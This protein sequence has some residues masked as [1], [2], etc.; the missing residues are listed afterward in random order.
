MQSDKIMI[1][2]LMLVCPAVA[3]LCFAGTS[4]RQPEADELLTKYV[5]TLESVRSFIVKSE[6]T[7]E[8]QWQYSRNWREPGFRGRGHKGTTYERLEI[9]TD[10]ERLHERS[11]KWGQI[12]TSFPSVSKDQ[13]TY[14]CRN[15]AN[16]ELY[17]HS[18]HVYPDSSGG[19]VML[20]KPQSYSLGGVE[21]R[22][23]GYVVQT[24]ER[25][26]SVLSR[27]KSISVRPGTAKIGDSDCYVI[28][29]ETDC[30]RVTVWIDPAHGY[31]LARAEVKA[32]EGDLYFGKPLNKEQV[33]SNHIEIRRFEKV[34]SIWIPMEVEAVIEN[35]YGP[36]SYSMSKER[37]KRT[38][39]VL[40]PDHNDL[41]SFDNPL[42]NP[43]NDP[44]LINGT[45]VHIADVPDRYKWQDGKVV[46]ANDKV[47]IDFRKKASEGGNNDANP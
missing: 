3:P 21:R 37:Y 9:R 27:T 6:S 29:A 38:E 36:G 46:D 15:Y 7:V 17:R 23:Q 30:G 2:I 31:H 4:N 25:V 32:T 16:G 28:D 35:H 26:D 22:L 41:D 24:H 13:P 11:Y 47:I 12:S 33:I 10:G 5:K 34:D 43:E 18:M 45:M 40:N 42:E 19:L 44:L 20:N 14:N 39:V 8:H 1:L